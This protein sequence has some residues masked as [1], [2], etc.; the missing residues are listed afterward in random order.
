MSEEEKKTG[1]DT[2]HIPKLTEENYCTWVQQLR[3]ILD[4]KELLEVVDGKEEKPTRPTASEGEEVPQTL[5]SEYETKLATWNKKMKKARSTIGASVTPSVM[6]YIDGMDDPAKMWKV[7]ADRYNPKSQATLLQLVREFMTTKKDD[8]LD[9]E[10]HLQRVQRLK[11]QVEEQGEKISDTIYNS[12]LLNSVSDDYKITVSILESQEQLTPTVIINRL[13]EETR[14]IYGVGGGDTKVALMSNSSSANSAGKSKKK[15]ATKINLKCTS[16]S[17]NGHV[18]I[19]CWTKHPEKRPTKSGSKSEKKKDKAD[20]KYAMS[21]VQRS[22]PADSSASHWYLDSGASEHFSP[23]R[24]LFETF[25]ELSDPCEI[26][27]AEGTTVMGT[28]IGNI[29]LTAVTNDGINTLHL[30]NVIYAPKMDANLLSTITLYDRDYEISMNPKKGVEILKDG[31]IVANAVRE[32]RLFKLRILSGS[33]ARTATTAESIRLWHHRLVHLGEDNVRKL[34]KMADGIKLDKDT[35][36]GV[37]SFCLE[38]RQTHQPSHEP[39][40][41]VNEPL[42]LIHSDTSGQISPTSTGGANYYATFTDDATKM[43]YIAP[44]ETKLAAEML[45]KFKEFKAEVENQLGRKIKRLRTDGG[46]E[47]KKAFGK[48]LKEQGIVHEK[49]VPY[50]P[51]QNGVSE[52]VNRMIM[53]R[54][55]AILAETGLPKIL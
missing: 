7:L 14:K 2:Y 27:T 25:K 44:M 5:Q 21:A 33:Q 12:V 30:N 23:H 22:P 17:K 13:L 9:M 29:T 47:Y 41:K 16:C 42:N 32:G 1:S 18:E 11:R 45:E 46:G 37:C 10:H 6:T 48:Y 38:G 24:H 39:S 55:R 53:D 15:D 31:T 52:R 35:S 28:G 8:S 36:V 49:T 3:W 26:T 54:A 4:E 43:S 51:D 20:A 50:S 34:E 40:D 19:D